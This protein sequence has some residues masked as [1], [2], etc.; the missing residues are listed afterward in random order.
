MGPRLGVVLVTLLLAGCAVPA[1]TRPVFP[2]YSPRREALSYFPSA[3]PVVA[4]VATDPQEP[5]LRR[6]AGSGALAPLTRAM[7]RRK[8]FVPQLAGLLGNDAVIG[9]PHV[10]SPPLAVLSTKDA[11]GLDI[12]ARARVIAHRATKAGRYRGAELY[13][14][15]GWAFAVRGRVLLV[16]RA[17]RDLTDALDT[18]VGNDA[19][20]AS[21]LTAVLPKSPPPATFARAFVNLRALVAARGPAARAVP[22]LAGLEG[23]GVAVGASDVEL[24]ATANVPVERAPIPARVE[25]LRP[26]VPARRPALAVADLAPLAAAAERSLAAALP[27]TALKLSALKERLR[28]AKVVLTPDLLHGPALVT[29]GPMLRLDAQRPAVVAAALERAARGLKT[30]SLQLR[31]EG[32]LFVAADRGRFL[33]RIGVIDGVLVAGRAS[34]AALLALGHRPRTALRKPALIRLPRASRL[35][36][37]PVVL[38][39]EGGPNR[40]R[41][42]AFSGY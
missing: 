8:V 41:V 1:A 24:R 29:S 7:D 25:G 10:G 26:A 23:A 18:R 40:V 27:V 37:R 14:E 17:L 30:P 31:R 28:A 12:L 33:A 15:D 21:Q 19:F 16:S 38:T 32:P 4:V 22:L 39:F 42:D 2:T 20:D 34:A 5:G 6:L 13:Q 36:P 9:V 35:Y 11:D 3:A